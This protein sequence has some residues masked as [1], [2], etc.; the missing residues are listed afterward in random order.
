[1]PS[2]ASS[3]APSS[4]SKP[5]NTQQDIIYDISWT[6]PIPCT[7]HA[8]I[9]MRIERIESHSN[10]QRKITFPLQPLE[11][12]KWRGQQMQMQMEPRPANGSHTLNNSC[13]HLQCFILLL[14]KHCLPKVFLLQRWFHKHVWLNIYLA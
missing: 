11:V 4:E 2:S 10:L 6:S 14:S 8:L 5:P 9:A 12:C 1:M 13:G 3:A 7:V